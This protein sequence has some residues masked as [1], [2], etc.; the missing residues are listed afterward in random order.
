MGKKIL[1]VDDE[2]K[3][4]K[5][6]GD[7][8]TSEGFQVITAETGEMAIH[9][10]LS[11]QPDLMVLDLM[12]P[13]VNGFEVCKR[14]REISNLPI[15]MLTARNEE[16]DKLVGLEFGADDY[17]TKPFSLRELVARIKAVIRRTENTIVNDNS[18]LQV[19]SL[20]LDMSR[21]EGWMDGVLLP[22]TPLEF[23][24]LYYLAA[25]P[26]LV[27]SRLQILE[28]VFGEDYEGYERSI[29]THISNIRKKL[30]P[31]SPE[32]S[33]I[34]TVYGVGYKFTDWKGLS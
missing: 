8:L 3:I 34:K 22:L 5:V 18:I 33:F 23:K 2:P 7:F 13:E 11:E 31:D 15:I 12:L 24:I 16:I 4:L 27:F 14:V 6:V 1:I 20:T 28:R 19:G 17:I 30:E 26:G 21:Y 9:L 32:S 10:A 29:D 25:N